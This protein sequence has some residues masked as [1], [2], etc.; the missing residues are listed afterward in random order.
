MKSQKK[1][2]SINILTKSAT[3]VLEKK[4]KKKCHSRFFVIVTST[5][6]KSC[7]ITLLAMPLI[8]RRVA[9]QQVTFDMPGRPQV[10][11]VATQRPK[12]QRGPRIENQ[13]LGQD[14]QQKNE[15]AQVSL[16]LLIVQHFFIQGTRFSS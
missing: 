6:K 11:V 13:L 8:H 10:E 3:A 16:L 12:I 9:G 14:P 2:L 5:R 15:S 7:Q 4:K 1:K